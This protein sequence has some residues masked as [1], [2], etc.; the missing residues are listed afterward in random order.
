MR[1]KHKAPRSIWYRE[2]TGYLACA[3]SVNY[4]FSFFFFLCYPKPM[5]SL[6]QE[7]QLSLT[8]HGCWSWQGNS[9]LLVKATLLT[10]TS[11]DSDIIQVQ[12]WFSSIYFQ[13]EHTL[14]SQTASAKIPALPPTTSVILGK[15]FNFFDSQFPL[16][17]AGKIIWLSHSR[18]CCEDAMRS[19]DQVPII[20]AQ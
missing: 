14:R 1:N 3:Y 19:A 2:G 13:Q 7:K 10:H 15:K 17:K 11:Q 12:L 4:A 16:H 8:T 20:N 5:F 18:R 6:Q 9:V